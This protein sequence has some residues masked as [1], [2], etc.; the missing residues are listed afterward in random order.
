MLYALLRMN[1]S[2]HEEEFSSRGDRESKNEEEFTYCTSDS[3]EKEFVDDDEFG[4]IP[5]EFFDPVPDELTKS[6][7]IDLG[8]LGYP[9][10]KRFEGEA[11]FF[12]CTGI[13]VDFNESTSRILTSASLIRTSDENMISDDLTIQVYLPNKQH[14]PGTLQYYDSGSNIAVI[15]VMG[16]RCLRTAVFPGH[17][18]IEPHREVVAIGRVFQSG[19]L[20]ATCGIL[21]DRK[22][23]LDCKEL[24][25]STC[26]MTKAGIGGPLIDYDGS[27]IGMNFYGTEETRYLP[28][29]QI[30]EL[31][32]RFDAEGHMVDKWPQAPR[33]FLLQRIPTQTDG[34][35][36][37]HFG[38]ILL[39]YVGGAH[40]RGDN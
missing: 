28:S 9:M 16:F 13:F 24:M 27:F 26:K 29:C 4:G 2:A 3:E 17:M 32:K 38:S 23:E 30:L 19:K 37:S 12:A 15:S 5:P 22:S 7:R 20:M 35:C 31:L 36:L 40:A 39:E 10:P 18:P 1:E 11:R 8:P 21:T 34:L 25:I 14:A 33:L 6:L